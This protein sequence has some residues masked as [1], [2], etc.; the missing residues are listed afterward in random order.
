MFIV[1][2]RYKDGIGKDEKG[3]CGIYADPMTSTHS[4]E[5]CFTAYKEHHHGGG[6]AGYISSSVLGGWWCTFCCVLVL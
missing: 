1:W 3:D 4:D 5:K 6:G 2:S